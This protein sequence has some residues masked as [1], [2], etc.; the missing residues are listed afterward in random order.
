MNEEPGGACELRSVWN[1]R[2]H[3]DSWPPSEEKACMDG[4]DK[5]LLSFYLCQGIFGI[6]ALLTKS[7]KKKK[8]TGKS[9]AENQM[10]F[11]QPMDMKISKDLGKDIVAS[12][13]S[14]QQTDT[15]DP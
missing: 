1:L 14:H 15:P 5:M 13:W 4:K 11:I 9:G 10:S 12:S 8:R 2:N 6:N 7:L 3:P